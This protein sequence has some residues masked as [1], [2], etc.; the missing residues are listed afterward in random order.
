MLSSP[1]FATITGALAL[2]A[3]FAAQDLMANFVAGIFILK[4]KPFQT[5]D[6]IEWN[7]N[8]GV[9]QEIEMRVTKLNSFDNE[10]MTVPN[11]D[12]AS[13]VVTN[14]VA[15][16]TLRVSY[17]FGISYDDDIDHAQE[18]IME[19]GRFIDGVL[20]EP[21]PTAPVIDLGGSSVVLTGRVW[22]DPDKSDVAP[23]RSAFVKAVKQR[24]DEEGIEMPYSHTELTGSVNIDQPITAAS[25][26]D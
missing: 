18:I 17:D 20:S 22:I 10:L 13:A 6:W 3:G 2:A 19:E 16:D 8:V 4:D 15:N 12:L 7:G 26:D 9:V 14:L 1:P 11:S 25:S 21:A 5:G 24:F 23:T